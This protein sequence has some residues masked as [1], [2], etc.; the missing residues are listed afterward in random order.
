MPEPFGPRMAQQL[1]GATRK[2]M[3]VSIECPL[4]MTLTFSRSMACAFKST[5]RKNQATGIIIEGG[6][7]RSE[8]K[9]VNAPQ[10]WSAAKAEFLCYSDLR[11][12]IGSTFA[13]RRAGR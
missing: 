4:R 2:E 3:S 8:E 9:N 13:A 1:P 5:A 12:T 11:A 7:Y 6:H 10:A